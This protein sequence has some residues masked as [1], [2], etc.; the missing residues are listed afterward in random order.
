MNVLRALPN[1]SPLAKGLLKVALGGTTLE[2][3]VRLHSRS[4]DLF[5][6]SLPRP[7]VAPYRFL[8]ALEKDGAGDP[9]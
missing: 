6:R 2:D 5:L 4:Y 8:S 1:E 9:T 7:R 3:E